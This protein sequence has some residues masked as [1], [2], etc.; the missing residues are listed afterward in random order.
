MGWS[1]V[2][3]EA[4]RGKSIRKTKGWGPRLGAT[5]SESVASFP[6]GSEQANALKPRSMGVSS[7]RMD[8]RNP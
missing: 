8:D 5:P 2:S 4:L 6:I 7:Q 1:G 3:G